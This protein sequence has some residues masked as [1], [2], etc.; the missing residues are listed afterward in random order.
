MLTINK[1]FALGWLDCEMAF[2]LAGNIA[3]FF[4][5]IKKLLS[6]HSLHAVYANV[7]DELES[8]DET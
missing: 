1:M 4:V 5:V 6:H 3:S 2:E 8:F 7:D